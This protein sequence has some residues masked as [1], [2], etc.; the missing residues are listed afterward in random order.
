MNR[1]RDFKRK[2]AHPPSPASAATVA[3]V[4]PI[5]VRAPTMRVSS[6]EGVDGSET[7]QQRQRAAESLAS[8]GQHQAEGVVKAKSDAQATDIYGSSDSSVPMVAAADACS[9]ASRA[10]PLLSSSE[11][12]LSSTARL[13]SVPGIFSSCLASA[14]LRKTKVSEG[15]SSNQ[16]P[17]SQQLR[18][19]LRARATV[20]RPPVRGGA[21]SPRG[22]VPKVCP[23]APL[24]S[25]AAAAHGRVASVSTSTPPPA[26]PEALSAHEEHASGVPVSRSSRSRRSSTSALPLSHTYS[27]AEVQGSNTNV[28]TSSSTNNR[29]SA[30]SLGNDTVISTAVGRQRPNMAAVLLPTQQLLENGYYLASDESANSSFS[31]TPRS[32]RRISLGSS[33]SLRTTTQRLDVNSSGAV[34]GGR[35]ATVATGASPSGINSL[36][37]SRDPNSYSRGNCSDDNSDI[38]FEEEN[39]LCNFD[40]EDEE[41]AVLTY[42]DSG[43]EGNLPGRPSSSNRAPP[44]PSA[45]QG[46]LSA[47]GAGDG[48]SIDPS[49]LSVSVEV[50]DTDYD[51]GEDPP[52]CMSVSSPPQLH[53]RGAPALRISACS[54]RSSAA[55]DWHAPTMVRRPTSVSKA[56][57]APS[58]QAAVTPAKLTTVTAVPRMLSR[59]HSTATAATSS[60]PT[61]LTTAAVH[62]PLTATSSSPRFASF[63]PS[64]QLSSMNEEELRERECKQL[65]LY[66]AFF[67]NPTRSMWLVDDH[68]LAKVLEYVRIMGYEHPAL[69]RDRLKGQPSLWSSS[70]A[71]ASPIAPAKSK[72]K[73]AGLRNANSTAPQNMHASSSSAAA[74]AVVEALAQP[75]SANASHTLPT[76]AGGSAD[77][78]AF[79]TKHFCL[80]AGKPRCARQYVN[81]STATAASHLF[82]TFS[83]AMRWIAEQEYVIGTV[84]L[85]CARFIGDPNADGAAVLGDGVADTAP[86]HPRRALLQR[87]KPCIPL[88]FHPIHFAASLVCSR[89]PQWGGMSAFTRAWETQIRLVLGSA[90]PS[91]QRL[92]KL[93]DDALLL[94]SD[95]EAGNL[96]RVER[97][98]EPYSF[99]IWLEP[100][101][102]SDKRIWFRFSVTGAKE[103]RRLR[104]RLMNAAPHV[105]LY[106]QNGMMPVWRDGLSQPNWGPVDSCSF[107]TTN[108]DLDGEVSFSI[109]P[110][111]STET[112]QIAFC[113]PYTYADLLCH[114][115]HW[116]ALVKSSGCDMRFE[117][118]VLCR[119]PD[120][121]KLH[122]LI[123]TSRV[124][125][126]P[127]LA[128][129]EDKSTSDAA[130][131][132]G[133]GHT[134]VG[135]DGVAAAGAGSSSG[136]TSPGVASPTMTI[137]P[138]KGKGGATKEAVRG[139][140]ANFASGKKVV[141]VSGRVHPGEVTASHGV[142]GLI[143]FL[144]SSDV[145]AIQLREHFIFFIV[146]MLNP[147][148]V[149]RGHSRMD[150]FGNN[151]NRC[152]NDPDAE[153]QP[154]VLALRRVF[155]HLQHTYRERFIMYLDFHSHASQSS[156]FMF[157]NNL[158]V[159]VQHW[160]LFFPRLVELHVRHV[161][162]FA[163]CRFGRVHMT[164]K[165]GASR[166]LFG[167][168][169]I[170]S[171]TVELPHFTDRRLYADEY[172]AMNNGS[173]VLFEVTWPPLHQTSGQAGSVDVNE[174]GAQDAENGSEGKW[175]GVRPA[176]GARGLYK[177]S[178][179]LLA[180][181][182]RACRSNRESSSAQARDGSPPK[183]SSG[184]APRS[185]G[186]A[187]SAGVGE[188]CSGQSSA[189]QIGGT[190]LASFLQPISTPSILCQSAEVGQ[191]C[192]LALRD[193]CSIGAR[194]SPE[195]TM[196]GGMDGVLRDSKRQVKLDSSRKCKKAQS[197]ATYAGINP[198]YKQ[199]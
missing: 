83:E 21:H 95:C 26:S 110:R 111:N 165:D 18:Q 159:S 146:P 190:R 109:N 81:R 122:L 180:G 8:Q 107:R 196:F 147:D 154:T 71:I 174:D 50:G 72:K 23:P 62:T 120:G 97:A 150:Q 127:A 177:R 1:P 185:Q 197:V 37:D 6:L 152:Y 126:A 82:L 52:S 33:S 64:L 134:G 57:G 22:G 112:I 124:G 55:A 40:E 51:I 178:N 43:A 117:E 98:G 11:P 139:P 74:E 184:A 13:A 86:W 163:L 35:S 194:P 140:Y 31:D 166:V 78:A 14:A 116:H 28:I 179:M 63:S 114:V 47:T 76:A 113:A 19:T 105:K 161:F 189:T 149:S 131:S 186:H 94:S 16:P 59:Q 80:K 171:Y 96:H 69:K 135:A 101:L 20:F 199:Y 65:S 15:H 182:G 46:L 84:L 12:A 115:C 143:S 151:L 90:S 191:A 87:R 187:N 67:F 53:R 173:N 198:I 100:D 148:G 176:V 73:A 54:V 79:A 91:H 128:A 102:G 75:G 175:R 88:R 58:F 60:R 121:R 157:G 183:K 153:T 9:R 119:S 104:F 5:P 172:A 29:G 138:G 162:S 169:L 106:R 32:A 56:S 49:S 125:G 4:S 39:D 48:P 99:L 132:G 158:P 164:S 103:G 45:R 118:R 30:R 24:A 155:E 108:R 77:S 66:E 137:P 70:S 188:H 38:M 156:G 123:V 34:G 129:T 2:T 7:P 195:L 133:R 61:P 167:S 89:F 3:S 68:V 92:F 36:R 141:L 130:I 27:G 41:Q 17:T 168:S 136:W 42:M 10:S 85:C 192:L 193:Y 93:P 44:P 25:G 142:H 145:R 144:L 170:H 181:R 160:N